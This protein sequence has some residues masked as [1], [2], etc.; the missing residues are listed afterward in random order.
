MATDEKKYELV[1]NWLLGSWAS[2][3]LD[4]DF[5]LVN[6]VRKQHEKDIALR[7]GRHL[8]TNS[9][10]SFVRWTWESIFD[11]VSEHAPQSRDKQKFMNYFENKTTGYNKDGELQ[12]AFTL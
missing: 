7:F 4:L 11:L 8:K 10:R 2:A 9:K 6:L 12:L 3:Q 5:H 1:R